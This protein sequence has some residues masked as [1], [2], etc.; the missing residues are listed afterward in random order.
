MGK[1]AGIR[2]EVRSG[3]CPE[4]RESKGGILSRRAVLPF[5]GSL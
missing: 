5:E 4:S 1:D 3:L 2:P